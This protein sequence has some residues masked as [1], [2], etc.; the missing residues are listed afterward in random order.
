M[1]TKTV[2]CPAPPALSTLLWPYLGRPSRTFP[3]LPT[4]W[5]P[6]ARGPRSRQRT[7]EPVHPDPSPGPLLIPAVYEMKK[8][9]DFLG[10]SCAFV[11]MYK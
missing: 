5:Q 8:Y 7:R 11:L 6:F 4:V 9:K 3:L 2:P 10:I 1:Q